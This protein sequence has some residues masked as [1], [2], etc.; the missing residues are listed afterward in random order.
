M[1][2]NVIAIKGL[3]RIAVL[4]K[5]DVNFTAVGTGTTTPTQSNTKLVTE[6]KRLATTKKLQS[7]ASSQL[8]TFFANADLPTTMEEAG[9]FM[10]GSATPDSGSLLIRA[11]INFV[12]GTND[13]LLLADI[14]FKEEL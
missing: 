5:D 9:W 6:T 12:K 11:L 2:D 14:T 1:P 3:E 8:R 10:N 4:V 7:G 13:L